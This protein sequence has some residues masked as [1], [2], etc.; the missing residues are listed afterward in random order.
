VMA[1]SVADEDDVDVAGQ[2]GGDCVL[3]LIVPSSAVPNSV[4]IA[5]GFGNKQMPLL[6]FCKNN[7]PIVVAGDGEIYDANCGN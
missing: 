1:D 5:T 7:K 4:A 6:K 3:L 2:E